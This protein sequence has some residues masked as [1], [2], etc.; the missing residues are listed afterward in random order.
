L[1]YYSEQQ[2]ASNCFYQQK[3]MYL[4]GNLWVSIT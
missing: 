1:H 3:I 4:C 2:S